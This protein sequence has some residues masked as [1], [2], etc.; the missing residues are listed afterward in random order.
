MDELKNNSIPV[1]KKIDLAVF[2]NIDKFKLTPGYNN[3]LDFYNG[4]E[5]EQQKV[6][7]AFILLV[8]FLIPSIFLG[9]VYWQNNNLKRDLETRIALVSKANEIIGQ[10]QSLRT[11]SPTIL[12]ENPIDGQEMMSSRLSNILSTLTMDLSKIKIDNYV[13]ELASTGVMKS[14]ADFKFTNISTDELMNIF[15]NMIQREKF[16]IQ[17]MSITRN[18]DTNLLNGEFHAVHLGNNQNIEEE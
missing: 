12:S 6:F 5:E 13:G 9:L 8:I 17:S 11:I 7:K 3:I 4:L 16:R 10:K 1:L 2:E 15:I 14:E 18:S